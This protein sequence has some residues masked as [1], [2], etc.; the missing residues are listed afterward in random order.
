MATISLLVSIITSKFI[1]SLPLYRQEKRFRRHGITLTRATMSNW[2]M[3]VAYLCSLLLP[4]MRQEIR[5]GPLVNADESSFQA[6][7]EPNRK[8]T[9]KSYIWVFRGGPAEKPVVLF[10]YEPSRSG[11][12]AHDFLDGYQGYVQTGGYQGYNILE[13]NKN[14][15]LMGCM[16]HARRKFDEVVK[17]NRKSGN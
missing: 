6:M 4:L 10:H 15:I 5:S 16:A 17:A 13:D 12:V 2:L 1:E 7:K 14:I 9:S 8:N 3:K 11:Q